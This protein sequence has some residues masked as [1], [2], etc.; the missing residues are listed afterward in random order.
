[1]D[2]SGHWGRDRGGG[3]KSSPLA[4]G[5]TAM[6]QRDVTPAVCPRRGRAKAAPILSGDP[7]DRPRPRDLQVPEAPAPNA[8]AQRTRRA[9]SYKLQVH[10]RS[11]VFGFCE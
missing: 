11:S 1:M 6:E 2:P 10:S 8:G 5:N 4:G 9:I 3:W 7:Q